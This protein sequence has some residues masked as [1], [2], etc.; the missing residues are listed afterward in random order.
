MTSLRQQMIDAMTVRGFSPR[1]HES[2]LYAVTQL[3]AYYH[4]SPDQITIDEQ[5]AWFLYLVKERHLSPASCRLYLNGLKFLYL[6]V[7]KQAEFDVEIPDGQSYR[8][9]S[10]YQSGGEAVIAELPWG[11]FGLTVCYDL[12]FPALYR[13]LAK[14]GADF[15]SVP[16]AFTRFTGGSHWHVLLRARAIETGCFVFAPA[17]CGEHAGGRKTYGHSLMVAPWGEVLADGGKEPGVTTARIDP[18]KVA[19]AR[20]MIPALTH[21]REIRLSTIPRSRQNP[22]ILG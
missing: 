5:R 8:E 21:D 6:Q 18:E 1:T 20:A 19:Q 3:A 17:Q 14:D 4:R 11:R 13:A 15:L 12:R 22:K 10:A 7:L 16:S 9:S 2:Y